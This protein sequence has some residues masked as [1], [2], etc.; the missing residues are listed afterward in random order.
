MKSAHD[1]L[2]VSFLVCLAIFALSVWADDRPTM[3]VASMLMVVVVG[4]AARL[5]QMGPA[6]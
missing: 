3:A 4:L 5:D 6:D 2:G 1:P